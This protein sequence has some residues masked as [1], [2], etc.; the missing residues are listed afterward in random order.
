MQNINKFAII[1]N[2]K[3]AT[4]ISIFVSPVCG[5]FDEDDRDLAE[6][7]YKDHE[8]L[9]EDDGFDTEAFKDLL[10]A[11]KTATHGKDYDQNERARIIHEAEVILNM[12]ESYDKDGNPEKC[13]EC[14]TLLNDMGTC[15]KCI[16][17]EEESLQEAS[18]S[19]TINKV[20]AKLAKDK[21]R[22]ADHLQALIVKTLSPDN[23]Y[24]Y[25][26]DIVDYKTFAH[27]LRA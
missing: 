10:D 22:K 16:E 6:A 13:P 23:R 27:I 26:G 17:G 8:W 7:N 21:Q 12:N 1:T 24:Y 5:E 4:T 18:I 20:D 11:F 25:K 3:I 19:D 9:I 15:P 2:I 14:D